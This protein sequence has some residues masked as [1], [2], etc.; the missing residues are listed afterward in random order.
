MSLDEYESADALAKMDAAVDM[1]KRFLAD[2]EAGLR[3][4]GELGEVAARVAE[5]T[6]KFSSQITTAFLK[7]KGLDTPE[8]IEA[9]GDPLAPLKSSP[10]ADE[11][12]LKMIEFAE[13]DAKA[14]R[15]TAQP[16]DPPPH[17]DV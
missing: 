14:W 7:M 15:L 17:P 2:A 16:E 1:S 10:A 4:P 5:V 9:G 3:Y 8:G 6:E 13:N 11:F 12:I